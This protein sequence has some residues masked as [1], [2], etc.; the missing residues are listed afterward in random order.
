METD[1]ISGFS[2][3]QE[4]YNWFNNSY[5]VLTILGYNLVRR[6]GQT[7]QISSLEK[8]RLSGAGPWGAK[9]LGSGNYD[10]AVSC[11]QV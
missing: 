10:L 7:R 1:T 5:D 11:R 8:L 2:W 4:L 6:A 3:K 9:R